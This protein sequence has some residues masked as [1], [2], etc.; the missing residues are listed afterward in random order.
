[1]REYKI[2]TLTPTSNSTLKS[3]EGYIKSCETTL[4]KLAKE[5]WKL[6]C[7][8]SIAQQ[9]MSN[10]IVFM[11]REISEVDASIKA[12]EHEI[13]QSLSES[14]DAFVDNPNPKSL[15]KN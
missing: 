10:L 14:M 11:A 13:P 8:E 1:M 3:M 15:P 2:I 6:V 9:D 7:T 4:N 5:G 12:A